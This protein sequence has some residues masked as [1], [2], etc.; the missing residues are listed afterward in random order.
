MKTLFA[1]L[2]TL[3]VST[4]SAQAATVWNYRM[5]P[6]GPVKGGK[7]KI[8]LLGGGNIK[9]KYKL[10]TS[11]GYKEDWIPYQLPGQLFDPSFYASLDIGERV[12]IGKYVV[13]RES[14]A[15]YLATSDEGEFRIFPRAKGG[16]WRRIEF[17]V[18]SGATIG[19]YG[20]LIN[21]TQE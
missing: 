8:H 1:I 11:V 14:D 18:K 10:D 5:E 17:T 9:F 12:Q 2:A 16:A 4:L 3:I 6:N 15:A 19:L 13:L 7:V 20:N 21:I